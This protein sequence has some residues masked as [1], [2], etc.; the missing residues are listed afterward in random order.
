MTTREAIQSIIK[1]TVKFK[2]IR[3]GNVVSVETASRTCVVNVLDSE[4]DIE[5]VRLHVT[6]ATASGAYYKPA[7]GSLVGISPLFSF[8]YAVVL[9]SDIEEIVF[10]DGSLGGLVKVEDLT[11]KLNNL[12]NKVNDIIIWGATVSP[13]LATPALVPTVQTDIENIK[14][15]HGI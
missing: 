12:E 8:E 15:S 3:L 1:D 13:P 5:G 9:Y 7:I 4:T 10:L 6:G 11:T 14:I 2:G